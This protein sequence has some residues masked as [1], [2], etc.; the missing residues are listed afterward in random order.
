MEQSGLLNAILPT[1]KLPQN[2][3][4]NIFILGPDFHHQQNKII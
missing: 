3:I 1:P 4:S 2:D